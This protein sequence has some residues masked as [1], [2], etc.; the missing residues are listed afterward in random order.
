M[1]L[2]VL[3]VVLAVGGQSLGDLL[4]ERGEAVLRL[5]RHV[6]RRDARAQEVI[7]AAG[8]Q[9]AELLRPFRV[10]EGQ[11]VVAAV[12]VRDHAA[13]RR[14][15]AAQVWQQRAGERFAVGRGG[16]GGAAELRL[17]GALGM[18]L[19]EL[20]HLVDGL[21]AADVALA[22]RVAPGEQAVAAEDD[23]VAAGIVLDRL[24]QHQRQLEPRPLPWHPDDLAAVL[25]VELL[26][27]GLAVGAR[28]QRDGPVGMQMIDVIEGQERVERRVDR[29][30]HAV[31]A[32]GEQRVEA[33][34]LVLELLAAVARDQAFELVEIEQRKSLGPDRSEIAAAAFHGHDARRRAGHRI[35]QIELRAGVAAAEVGDAQIGAEHVRSVAQELERIRF[36][37]RRLALVPEI[38]QESRFDSGRFRHRSTPDTVGI[39]DSVSSTARC[40]AERTARSGT[41]VR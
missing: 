34:H 26:E 10:G 1:R 41:I 22:L 30:G 31:L 18:L 37:P 27:P 6:E 36:E 29:G 9:A 33:H 14:H 38:L 12:V 20:A 15:G 23:A 19:D 40:R 3:G 5:P 32:E 8:A 17:A 28:R 2:V 4:L 13:V 24:A 7:G 11:R 39:F 25:L 16:G 35:G 21:D